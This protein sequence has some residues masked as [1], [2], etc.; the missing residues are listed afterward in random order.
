M[1]KKLLSLL[2]FGRKRATLI[3]TVPPGRRGCGS[4]L[5]SDPEGK[6]LLGGRISVAARADEALARSHGNPARDV[7]RPYGDPACGTYL[8]IATDRLAGAP[9]SLRDEIGECQLLFEP[10][11]GDAARAESGGRL[12]LALHGG[13]LGTD[14][15]LRATAGG[16]R[17]SGRDLETLLR[18]LSSTDEWRLEL[19]EE[20]P[21]MLPADLSEEPA[22][23]GIDPPVPFSAEAQRAI[24]RR[25]RSSGSSD[26]SWRDRHD[27]D[28]RSSRDTY[29]SS[30]PAVAAATGA[31]VGAAAVG[32]AAAQAAKVSE[33]PMPP[34]EPEGG[35]DVAQEGSSDASSGTSY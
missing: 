27:D 6:D 20:V 23:A 13:R 8:L 3:V 28:W 2:G 12:M 19:R 5:A 1:L 15:R 29:S 17:V 11:E 31:V 10:S 26:D 22:G 14:N 25:S 9:E 33:P 16:L 18:V 21:K 7:M 34:A 32:A 24:E 4:L 35:A 30:G